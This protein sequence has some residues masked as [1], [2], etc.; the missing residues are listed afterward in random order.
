MGKSARGQ[1]EVVASD[2]RILFATM[3]DDEALE[4]V[5]LIQSLDHKPLEE[6]FDTVINTVRE[7]VLSAANKLKENPR[8]STESKTG[9]KQYLEMSRLLRSL[10]HWADDIQVRNKSPLA[11]TAKDN[12]RFNSLALILRTQFLDITLACSVVDKATET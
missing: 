9:I 4:E 5:H 1:S 11:I 3:D 8:G 12:D 6:L 2:D 7:M 10:Q